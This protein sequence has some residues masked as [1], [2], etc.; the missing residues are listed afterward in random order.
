[1]N[2]LLFL[3]LLI[4]FI[5]SGSAISLPKGHILFHSIELELDP[6]EH[7]LKATDQFTIDLERNTNQ[8]IT[9]FLNKDLS[10]T[11]LSSSGTDLSYTI[12]GD[13][14]LSHFYDFVD[15]DLTETY[16]TAVAVTLLPPPKGWQKD[17]L[18]VNIAYH[19]TIHDTTDLREDDRT[20]GL[21][22][23]RGTFLAGA[24]FW[25][26]DIPHSLAP[27]KLTATQPES[28]RIITQGHKTNESI[29]SG[30]RTETWS[31]PYPSD[32]IY[33]ISGKYHLVEEMH[34][35]VS[36]QIWLYEPDSALSTNYLNWCKKY[37]D[38]YSEMIGPYPYKQ[39]AVV[40]N[41]FQTG[42]GMPTFTLLGTV[43]I[44]LPHI[45]MTSLGHEILHNWWG[46]S[47][48]VDYQSGNWCEGLTAYLA[49]HR[50]KKLSSEA[51]GIDYR[52][53]T[54]QRYTSYV[55]K[56]ND[57]PL[58][59]FRSRHD[60]ATQAIGYGKSLMFFHMLKNHIGEQAFFDGLSHFYRNHRFMQASWSDIQNAF[61]M[62][63]DKDLRPHF[64]QWIARPGA[65][66]I[67]L[68]EAAVT[69]K[70]N[71]YVVTIKVKQEDP[72]FS[73]GLPIRL[74]TG[75]DSIDKVFHFNKRQAVFEI[76]GPQKPLQ[77]AVDPEHDV[78]RQ[79]LP[80]EVPP[81]FT[82]FFGDKSRVTAFPSQ[83]VEQKKAAYEMLSEKLN[84][85]LKPI[86]KNDP[87]IAEDD[88]HNNSILILGG[89]DE[90][91]LLNDELLRK[92]PANVKVE[93]QSFQVLDQTFSGPNH[94]VALVMANPYNSDH[95]VMIMAGLSEDVLS[96][97][98]RK[99]P[100]YGKYSYLVFDGAANVMKGVWEV[101]KSP[102]KLVLKE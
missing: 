96:N 60:P 101:N 48:Y 17:T 7:S 41:F 83:A 5:T 16:K 61:Q 24:S 62:Q 72:V 74:V 97:G 64:E 69:E 13:F 15:D 93:S 31:F 98:L 66:I 71:E 10:I 18:S 38:M 76:T 34:Q 82:H 6:Y 68:V 49:D 90:N 58:T 100:H 11:A 46:N 4:F 57:I 53:N 70:E 39:F 51:L 2:I 42:Y 94:G 85:R 27:F 30:R 9:F 36:L 75:G 20:T 40:E 102:L 21:I 99:V 81:T 35:N 55:S 12:S 25:Y 78:F 63:S 92:M 54:C 44:R 45:V 47:V 19:G 29:I 22:D 28:Y 88:W 95:Y 87:D 59:D 79:L 84:R 80:G 33:C 8:P 73:I 32:E 14:E 23:E 37:M 3:L 26:P 50:Y 56:N 91:N 65:P 52:R 86:V 77:I 43:V 89:R 67:H 1:M